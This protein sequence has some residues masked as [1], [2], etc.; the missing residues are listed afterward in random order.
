MWECK[1]VFVP[2]DTYLSIAETGYEA[3]NT[4]RTQYQS[5]LGPLMYAMLGTR[6]EI[7]VSLSILCRYYSNPDPGY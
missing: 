2:M 5:A 1:P 7:A 6:P 4:F 3:T